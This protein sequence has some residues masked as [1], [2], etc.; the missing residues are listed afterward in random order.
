MN[1]LS[2]MQFTPLATGIYLEGL[3]VDHERE[4]IWYSD[5]VG[6]GIHGVKPDGTPV[7]VLDPER[8]W[9]AAS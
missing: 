5:V 1:D 2:A 9:T 4:V 7:G 8:M 3:A 6:G